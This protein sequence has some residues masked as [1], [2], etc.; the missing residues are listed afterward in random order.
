M[1]SQDSTRARSRWCR[2]RPRWPPTRRSKGSAAACA[3]CCSDTTAPCSGG[4]GWIARFRAT[5]IVHVRGRHDIFGVK[6]EELGEQGLREAIDA[7]G[8]DVDAFAISS[9][10]AARNP[11]HEARARA[12]AAD[13]TDKPVVLGGELSGQLNSVRRATSAVLNAAADSDDPGALERD[14]HKHAGARDRG[15]DHGR[16]RRR[17]ADGRITGARAPDRDRGLGGRRPAWWGPSA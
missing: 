13:M 15:P 5:H 4:T 12:I 14:R 10:L 16:P 9:Y 17:V 6:T 2:W 3:V 1:D 11:E 8:S 7:H